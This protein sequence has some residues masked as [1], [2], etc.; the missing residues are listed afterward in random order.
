M[1]PCPQCGNHPAQQQPEQ[2]PSVP[3]IAKQVGFALMLWFLF[4]LVGG[5][6]LNQIS[7]I[8]CGSPVLSS[9]Q[10]ENWVIGCGVMVG[11]SR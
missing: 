11:F 1:E 5:F 9:N 4:L 3:A 10:I 6:A 8:F 7:A 2:K